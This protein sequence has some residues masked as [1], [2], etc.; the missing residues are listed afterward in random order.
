MFYTNCKYIVSYVNSLERRK[1]ESTSKF[2]PTSIKWQTKSEPVI[3]WSKRKSQSTSYS[4]STRKFNPTTIKWQKKSEPITKWSYFLFDHLMT[5]LDFVLHL[6]V[7][8]LNFLVDS[9]FLF[10]HFVDR[11]FHVEY[12]LFNPTT[13]KWQKKSEPITKWSKR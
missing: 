9:A 6:I 7:A 1:Y 12:R 4:A 2:K 13:I 11:K 5:G 3:K 10:D 8:G